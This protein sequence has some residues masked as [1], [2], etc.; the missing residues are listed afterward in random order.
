MNL[1]LALDSQNK[2]AGTRQSE[3]DR[4]NKGGTCMSRA[5]RG[6]SREPKTMGCKE[7]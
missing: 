7:T 3:Q 1:R 2:A 4:H 6:A 5:T